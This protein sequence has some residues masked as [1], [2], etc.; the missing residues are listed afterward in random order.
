MRRSS[1][2]PSGAPGTAGFTSRA[3]PRTFTASR[4]AGRGRGWASPTNGVEPGRG[5]TGCGWRSRPLAPTSP[6][7]G[8]W[9][10]EG[11]VTVT[12]PGSCWTRL[13]GARRRSIGSPGRGFRPFQWRARSRADRLIAELTCARRTTSCRRAPRPK[14]FVKR[15]RF[16]LFDASPPAVRA[17]G[18]P[19]L[20]AP[21][22]RAT[23]AL[24][25]SA[26]DAGS[27][28]RQVAVR[29]NRKLFD[30]VGVELQHRRGSAGPRAQPLPQLGA[31][32]RSRKHAHARLPRGAELDRGLRQRLRG[33]EPQRALRKAQDPGRQRLPDLRR[34]PEAP[35]SVRLRERQDGEAGQ[36]R[37]PPQSGRQVRAALGCAW[38][39]RL[40]L[41]L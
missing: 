11:A 26:R 41:R 12:G 29:T 27:G 19:L 13:G 37:P 28:V 22:Q 2:R 31:R 6:A 10:A 21:V 20:G 15:A 35:R 36:V 9:H 8:S 30:T 3:T 17:L 32:R 38:A 16:H 24:R 33:G 23:Q 4:P 25:V 1:A 5:D 7:A 40:G 34:H 14:I 18:G 39:G